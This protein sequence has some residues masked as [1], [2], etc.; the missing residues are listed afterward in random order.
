M[1]APFRIGIDARA[2]K[3]PAG[4]MRRYVWEIYTRLPGLEPGLEA[5]AVGATDD[6]ALPPGLARRPAVS[7]PTNLG[8]M[9][10]SLPLAIRGAGLDVFHAPTYTAPLWGVHPQAV[11]IHDVSCERVPE[12]NAYK[13]DRARRWFYRRSALAAD[14]VI[15]DSQFSKDEIVAAYGVAPET[16][17]VIPLAAAATFTPGPFDAA[18]APAGVRQ[19]YLLH[20]GDLQVRR[21]LTTALA[22]VL[23][24]RTAAGHSFR[25][26]SAGTDVGRPFRSAPGGTAEALPCTLVCAGV[27]RGI[28]ADL[29]AQ[30]RAAGDPEA[31]VL[32]GPVSEAALLNLYRGAAMLVYPSRYEGFGLPILE[33]MQCGVPV[34]AANSSSLPELVGGAGPLVPALDVDAWSAAMHAILSNPAEAA[35]LRAASLV[36]AA[37]FSWDRTARETLAA[38]RACAFAKATA[39]KA[40]P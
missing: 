31:L 24:L 12:W 27:D 25:G 29:A 13:N 8:W 34:V 28:G 22:A 32:T 33:A 18:A 1:S 35:R 30:A 20:V 16:I 10:A 3:S 26:A 5:I 11:T 9:A 6:D 2:F 39:P 38:L 7:F 17:R 36:R 21:N 40:A 23:K 14:A 4:G 37:L 15:T 19:P